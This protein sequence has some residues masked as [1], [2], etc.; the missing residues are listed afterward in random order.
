[1]S[2]GGLSPTRI[3]LDEAD[4]PEVEGAGLWRGLVEVGGAIVGGGGEGC[5]WVVGG[6]G[7]ESLESRFLL[8]V[9][10]LA[11]CGEEES[12]ESRLL[13]AEDWE[14]E[15]GLVVSCLDASAEVVGRWVVFGILDRS[16]CLW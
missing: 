8:V 1:M 15:S 10:S 11:G 5:F 3:W 6:G 7:E 13:V 12:L 4:G 14:G 16:G 9:V 2:R